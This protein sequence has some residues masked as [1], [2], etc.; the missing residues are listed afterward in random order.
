MTTMIYDTTI[1]GRYC[2]PGGCSTEVYTAPELRAR[3]AGAAGFRH[4]CSNRL[5]AE[6]VTPPEPD[7]TTYGTQPAPCPQANAP[8]GRRPRP[9]PA[10]S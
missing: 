2:E 5:K 1:T 4:R 9:R 3:L 7:A 6:P 10:H 8:T